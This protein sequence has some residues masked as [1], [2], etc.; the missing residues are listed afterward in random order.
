MIARHSPGS[1]AL[2]GAVAGAAVK[3]AQWGAAGRVPHDEGA[4][5]VVLCAAVGAACAVLA[6][7]LDSKTD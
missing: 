2:I 3:L 4:L 6:V 5:Q 1:A 7:W